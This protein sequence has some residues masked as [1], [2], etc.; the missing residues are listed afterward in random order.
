VKLEKVKVESDVAEDNCFRN[1]RKLC[2]KIA[3]HASYN[4]K[5]NIGAPYFLLY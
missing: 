2:E 5:S 3:D 1:F 4:D